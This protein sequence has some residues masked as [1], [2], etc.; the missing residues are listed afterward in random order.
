V[1]FV[2]QLQR[3]LANDTNVKNNENEL[4]EINTFP[5]QIRKIESAQKYLD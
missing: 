3:Y 2:T 4:N 1:A 5:Y